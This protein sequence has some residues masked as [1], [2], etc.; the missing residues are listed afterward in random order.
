MLQL[1]PA[2][3]LVILIPPQSALTK[4]GVAASALES[5]KVMVLECGFF[6]GISVSSQQGRL[7]ATSSILTCSWKSAC[8][9]PNVCFCS[10]WR[11]PLPLCQQERSLPHK[12]HPRRRRQGCQDPRNMHCILSESSLH[13]RTRPP[14]LG[15]PQ[16]SVPSPGI[17]GGG[18]GSRKYA[19]SHPFYL[20]IGGVRSPSLEQV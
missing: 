2:S 12:C 15:S 4:L 11:W 6:G 20:R 14:F 5:G 1:P 7:V 3:K 19:R 8:R 10:K 16:V 9:F 18:R 13:H 17:Q